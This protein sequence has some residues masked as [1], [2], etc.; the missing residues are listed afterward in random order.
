MKCEHIYSHG[1]EMKIY[2]CQKEAS[3][4]RQWV[5]FKGMF[6]SELLC[7]KCAA[8]P[9]CPP[10]NKREEAVSE[11]VKTYDILVSKPVV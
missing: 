4:L 1:P 7:R 8:M 3:V 2:Q 6:E 10:S 9:Q 11:S 5:N